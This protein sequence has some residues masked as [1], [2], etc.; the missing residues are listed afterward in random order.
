MIFGKHINKY[1]KKYWE[2]LFFGFFCLITIDIIQLFIPM[3]IGEMIKNLS[4]DKI[5]A[6]NTINLVWNGRWF[7]MTLGY[8][9]L[10]VLVIGVIITVGRIGWRISVFKLGAKIECDLREEMFAHIQDLP[11]SWFA[12]QKTGALMAYYTND[13]EDIKECCSMGLVTLV[14]IFVLGV[15]ALIFMFITHWVLALC[16][17]VPIGAILGL[18]FYVMKGEER[19]WDK[20][21]TAFQKMSDVAQESITGLAV[22]KA[23]VREKRELER[24]N[25]TNVMLQDA[26]IKFFRFSQKWGN[27]CE[28]ILIYATE[29]IILA[30]GCYFA[31][32]PSLS[33]PLIPAMS[34]VDAAG[35][36]SQFLGYFYTLLWPLQAITMLIDLTSRG[37]SSLKRIS[38]ILD[39]ENDV[40]DS[41]D[42][43]SGKIQGEIEYKNLS[44]SYPDSSSP[45][46]ENISFKINKG[47]NVGIVGRTGSGKSSLLTL[48]MKLYN[49]P[50]DM[51]YIDGID[52]NDWYGKSLRESIGFV[53]Q[54]AFL[55]SDTIE[56]NIAF[57]TSKTNKK[58]I[59]RASM[60]A[61]I[62]SNIMELP[63]A[64]DT[65][66]GERG[67]SV[68]GGQRQR[69]SIARAVIKNP[70]VLILDDSVSAVDAI[71]EKHILENIQEER[72]GQTTF[73]IS[74]RLSAVENLDK[75][76]VIDEGKLVGVGT[77]ET[78]LNTCTIYKKLYDLQVLQKELD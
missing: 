2:N 23:F 70:S 19:L 7:N 11:V 68:S 50:K 72:K 20:G 56:G 34:R 49:I 17:L 45:T 77:H 32:T 22:V 10:S 55:F 16:C 8:V 21:Q 5:D 14:D 26:N 4:T 76:I 28:L 73:I 33:F 75:I 9:L 12:K 65:L 63:N 71:T 36:L 30:I 27:V 53:S 69:I 62:D 60:F 1:Y 24:F 61:D 58:E 41:K 29:L 64:Y 6:F 78:L 3:I 31:L 74:S 51:I 40:I 66:V 48:L 44:F 46:L 35:V 42:L 37:K 52:I 15:C 38:V 18:S 47:E 54:D 43:H 59:R 67:K 57:G 25:D 13:L 39:T